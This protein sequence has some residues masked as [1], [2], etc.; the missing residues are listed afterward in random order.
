MIRIVTGDCEAPTL[1]LAVA[2]E[3]LALAYDLKRLD[4]DHFEQWGADHRALS[5]DGSAPVLL[6]DDACMDHALLGLYFLAEA[7]PDAGLMPNDPVERYR[8][9]AE[10]A[11]MMRQM[12]GSLNLVGWMRTVPADQRADY[13]HRLV[14]HPDRPTLSGWSA[15]WRD[16]IPEDRRL[17]DAEAKILA[18]ID[19]V[20]DVL[21]AG[22]WLVGQRFSVA[23]IVGFALLRLAVSLVPDG[24]GRIEVGALSDWYARIAARQSA[25]RAIARLEEAELWEVFRPPVFE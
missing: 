25:R 14:Q 3:E 7:N 22:E 6:M 2:L 20:S 8:V 24:S 16:A 13:L 4:F 15:V 19:H 5:A 10:S 12:A 11:T 21:G 17:D 18:G 9:Q 23:D 1:S